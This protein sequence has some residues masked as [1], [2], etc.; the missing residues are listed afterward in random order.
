MPG[1][2][3]LPPAVS[4][5]QQVLAGG[6]ARRLLLVPPS[7]VVLHVY[8]TPVWKRRPALCEQTGDSRSCWVVRLDTLRG[9][10]VKEFSFKGCPLEPQW[11]CSGC[12]PSLSYLRLPAESALQLPQLAFLLIAHFTDKEK[13]LLTAHFHTSKHRRSSSG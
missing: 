11:G 1:S 13:K 7:P 6:A 10:P 2:A 4:P 12:F 3:T 8:A 5:G 9:E